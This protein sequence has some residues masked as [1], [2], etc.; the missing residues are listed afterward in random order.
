MM[1]VRIKLP[2]GKDIIILNMHFSYHMAKKERGYV[3]DGYNAVLDKLEEWINRHKVDLLVGDF[4]GA[5][6]EHQSFG[7]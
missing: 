6:K 7:G 2:H 1:V 3:R 4:N 5:A